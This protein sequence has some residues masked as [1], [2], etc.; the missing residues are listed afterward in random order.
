MYLKELLVTLFMTKT[1]KRYHG[2][3]PWITFCIDFNRIQHSQWIRLGEISAMCDQI[4]GVPLRP[5]VARGLHRI[6]L[7]K[8]ALATTAIEGNTL[9]EEEVLKQIEGT[10]KVPPS[11][12]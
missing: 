5:S 2:S 1:K 8:G 10:L 7:A 6:Y 9:S 4:A 11:K 12:K 3:H